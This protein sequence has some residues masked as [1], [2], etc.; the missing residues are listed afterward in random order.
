MFY[1]LDTNECLANGGVGDCI[2]GATC[3]NNDG[4]FTCNCGDGWDGQLCQTGK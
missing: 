2:N 1:F 4:S 3:T